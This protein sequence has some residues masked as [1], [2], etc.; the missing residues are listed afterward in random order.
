MA[1]KKTGEKKKPA[2]KRI[3]SP[4]AEN[5]RRLL[6]ERQITASAAAIIA[7]V[8]ISTVNGWLAGGIQP[9]NFQAVQRL[10]TALKADFEMLLCGTSH[11][12]EPTEMPLSAIFDEVDVGLQGVYRLSLK[13]L[14]RKGQS[15]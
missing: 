14:V 6:E 5:L 10:S 1:T 2:R 3:E 4:F 13:R 11:A 12:F 7:Q 8:P 9:H 15:E